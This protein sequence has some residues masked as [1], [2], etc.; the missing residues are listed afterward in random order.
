MKYSIILPVRNGG[1]YVKECV[2]SILSQTL[3][4]FNLHVLDNCST[5]GTLEWIS[6]LNDERIRISPSDK[7]LSIE[8]NFKRAISTSKNQFMTLIGHDDILLNNYLQVMDELIAEHPAASLYQTHFSYIDGMG[9]RI[10]E[11]KPMNDVETAGDFLTSLLTNSIDIRGTGFM[12][13][14]EDYDA[15]GG[16]PSYPN[17]LFA[18]YELWLNLT[19]KSYKATAT[20]NC[21][22]YRLHQSTTSIS[23]DVKLHQAFEQFIYFLKSLQNQDENLRNVIRKHGEQFLMVN[24]KGLSHR[25]LRT[26]IDKRDNLSVKT[27]LAK[28]KHYAQLLMTGDN[29]KP[30]SDISIWL[31]GVL[32]S[33]AVGRRLFLGFKRVYSRPVLK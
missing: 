20:Q 30:T 2:S 15:L 5:D 27:F 19:K 3:N 6:S 11:C 8:E 22:S 33:S 13:R 32:D 25:L 12:M 24:C 10:R 23:P 16:I 18:D 1:E 31:A 26:P 9:K 4:D 29:F 14:S 7:P 21:F 28:C 17:L